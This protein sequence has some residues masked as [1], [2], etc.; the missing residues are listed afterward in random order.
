FFKQ[1]SAYEL[2]TSL[3]F[4]RV[5]FRSLPLYR[6]RR[7]TRNVIDDAVDMILLLYNAGG[8]FL[9]YI[10]RDARPIRCHA[11]DRMDRTNPNR[12]IICAAVACNA[13]TANIR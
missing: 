4:R 1:K 5:L 7:L 9:Q 2:E 3:E 11:I 6:R 8:N 12:M 10:P 13:H